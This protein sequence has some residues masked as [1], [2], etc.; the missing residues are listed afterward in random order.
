MLQIGMQ[1]ENPLLSIGINILLPVIILNKVSPLGEAGPAVALILALSLPVGYG[2]W[3]YIQ[4]RHKNMISLLGVINILFTGGLALME[5][6]GI[7]FAVKEA[8]FPL[9]IGVAVAIS[10]FT[11]KP[12]VQ[13]IAYNERV[14]N[15][16]RIRQGLEA[17]QSHQALQLHL[18]ISTLLFAVS[19][20]ISSILNFVLARRIFLDIDPTLS[21]SQRTAVLNEQIAAMTWQSFLVIALPLMIFSALI[22]WHLIHGVRKYTGLTLEEILPQQDKS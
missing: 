1:K 4:R 18:K 3:D 17:H 20:F 16:D 6:E 14:M 2:L 21:S 12:F 22:L 19:F 11:R 8:A 9:L 15:L 13:M 5:L 10:A 7:W